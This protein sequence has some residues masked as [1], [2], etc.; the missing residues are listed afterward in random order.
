MFHWFASLGWGQS[1]GQLRGL[2]SSHQLPHFLLWWF[3]NFS[4]AFSFTAAMCA[5]WLHQ[6][7][8]LR[9]GMMAL[10]LLLGLGAEIGQYLELVPGNFDWGDLLAHTLG[11]GLGCGVSFLFWGPRDPARTDPG[12]VETI[13]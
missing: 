9:F 3:P 11:F 8:K 13:T 12:V 6:P 7:G 2:L 5:L 4:W 10:P 1:V